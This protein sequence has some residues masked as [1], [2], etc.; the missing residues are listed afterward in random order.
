MISFLHF[1]T[2]F[3]IGFYFYTNSLICCQTKMHLCTINKFISF[4]TFIQILKKMKN[5]TILSKS[6][7]KCNAWTREL[8]LYLHLKTS[9]RLPSIMIQYRLLFLHELTYLLPDKNLTKC[10]F[11][12]WTKL[13]HFRHSFH[14]EFTKTKKDEKQN[15]FE[16]MR[17]QMWRQ[18]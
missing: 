17:R 18:K 13:F 8:T 1:A 11:V 7:D 9:L 4:S 15:N 16:K 3:S 12:Q 14:K 10:T 5:T 6:R 2:W